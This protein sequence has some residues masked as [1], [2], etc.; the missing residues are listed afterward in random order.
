MAESEGGDKL[1]LSPPSI[2]TGILRGLSKTP[3]LGR[4]RI[5]ALSG[6]GRPRQS[7]KGGERYRKTGRSRS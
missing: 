2:G 4:V 1:S 3:A 5:N 7:K 6:G